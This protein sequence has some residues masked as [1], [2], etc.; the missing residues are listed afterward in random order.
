MPLHIEL[1]SPERILWEGEAEMV[2]ARTL[3]AGDIAFLPG[4]TPFL[5]A[6]DIEV[7]TIRPAEGDDIKAAVHGGFISVQDDRVIIL[8]DIAELAGQIDLQRAESARERAEK[9]AMQE[10]DQGAEVSLR[11]AHARLKAAGGVGVGG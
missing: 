11:R 4:H 9:E 5:G 8:S 6:L 2:L 7:V 1:V 10:D 3:E